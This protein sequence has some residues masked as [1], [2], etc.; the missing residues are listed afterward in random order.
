MVLERN[1]EWAMQR[2]R[3]SLGTLGDLGA[4]AGVRLPAIGNWH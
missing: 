2:C 1:D 4:S 3:T